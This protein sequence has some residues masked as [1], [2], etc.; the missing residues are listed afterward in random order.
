EPKSEYQVPRLDQLQIY[1]YPFRVRTTLFS[2]MRIYYKEPSQ[3]TIAVCLFI[4]PV[5]KC[6]PKLLNEQPV[7]RKH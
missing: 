7:W 2:K 4:T 6:P 1:S 5:V 3:F